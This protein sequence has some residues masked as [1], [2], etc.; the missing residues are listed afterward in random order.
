MDSN[1]LDDLFESIQIGHKNAINPPK[2]LEEE[3]AK[4]IEEKNNK[5]DIILHGKKGYYRPNPL[6]KYD[7]KEF[8]AFIAAEY[9]KANVIIERCIAMNT[10]YQAVLDKMIDAWGASLYDREKSECYI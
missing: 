3:F 6:D 2:E 7:A 4:Y 8:D 9:D 10:T 1:K 5:G